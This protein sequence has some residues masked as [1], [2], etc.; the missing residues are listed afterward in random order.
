MSAILKI[1]EEYFR[2]EDVY[3]LKPMMLKNI[4]DMT[5][6]DFST[7]SR[8]TN[9]KYLATPWGIFPLR[10]FFSDSKGEERE[11]TDTATNRKIEA[12][13]VALIDKEDKRHP[14]S[15]RRITEDMIKMGYDVSRRTV[16]KYRDRQKIPV[17]RLRKEM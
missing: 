15:D 14:L 17:A 9:N 4:S 8:A 16:A 3:T 7:I 5:G 6:L 2:T 11:G 12:A 10:F 1:Q 13:I